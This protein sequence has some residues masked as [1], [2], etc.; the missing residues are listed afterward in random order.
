MLETG[1][2]NIVITGITIL[3]IFGSGACLAI[4]IK[5]KQLRKNS[6]MS[7]SFTGVEFLSSVLIKQLSYGSRQEERTSVILKY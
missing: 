3:V 4:I 6:S 2:L 1:L 7:L 5:R